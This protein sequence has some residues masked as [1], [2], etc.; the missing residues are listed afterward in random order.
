MLTIGSV[1]F[2][3]DRVTVPVPD[4]LDINNGSFESINFKE[5]EKEK[6]SIKI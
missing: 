1:T 3:N 4:T 6:I 2:A 5:L